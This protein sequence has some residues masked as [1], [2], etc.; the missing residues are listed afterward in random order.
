MLK[1]NNGLKVFLIIAVIALL[2]W[3]VGILGTIGI[4]IMAYFVF[5]LLS[6]KTFLKWFAIGIV[7]ALI[8]A[9]PFF[10]VCVIYGGILL[11]KEKFAEID[12]M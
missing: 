1:E 7:C 6:I 11:V 5:A 4:G 8:G 10:F 3:N 12:R 9:T 2:I